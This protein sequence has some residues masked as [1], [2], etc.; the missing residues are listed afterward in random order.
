MRVASAPRHTPL[1]STYSAFF[2]SVVLVR[3]ISQTFS[4][5]SPARP[6][7]SMC[8]CCCARAFISPIG[9]HIALIDCTCTCALICVVVL[10]LSQASDERR[11]YVRLPPRR[12]LIPS[13]LAARHGLD[14]FLPKMSQRARSSSKCRECFCLVRS[15]VLF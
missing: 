2:S 5:P 9:L 3:S 10:C 11:F 14:S 1:A 8:C 4:Y 6:I 13:L 7:A 15:Y 12:L